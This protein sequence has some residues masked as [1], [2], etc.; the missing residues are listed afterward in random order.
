MVII[1]S[2]QKNQGD[3]LLHYSKGEKISAEEYD[4]TKSAVFLG[5]T[6]DSKK[7]YSEE[8]GNLDNDYIETLKKGNFL[9]SSYRDAEKTI[10]VYSFVLARDQIIIDKA[11][12]KVFIVG[13]NYLSPTKI[14]GKEHSAI[15]NQKYYSYYNIFDIHEFYKD[16]KR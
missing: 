4:S 12:N 5:F 8:I 11:Y 10:L 6:I 3:E 7:E 2:T 14:E 9:R 1:I 15:Y 16:E 13:D